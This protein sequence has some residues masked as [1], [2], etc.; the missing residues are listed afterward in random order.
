MF[1]LGR[2]DILGAAETGSG[3]T[4]AF[5]LPILTGILKMKEKGGEV[6][7]VDGGSDDEEVGGEYSEETGRWM[8]KGEKM[9]CQCE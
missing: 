7:E 4:L 9:C 1:V 2:R 6:A 3:K 8:L 5:G